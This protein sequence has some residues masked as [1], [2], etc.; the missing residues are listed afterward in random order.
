MEQVKDKCYGKSVL[1]NWERTLG[2]LG[3]GGGER[4]RVCSVVQIER[5]HKMAK[6]RE[7]NSCYLSDSIWLIVYIGALYVYHND[8]CM[9]VRIFF[10]RQ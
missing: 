9:S 7:L 8:S 6:G 1:S 2:L 3:F 5:G 4:M 10:L